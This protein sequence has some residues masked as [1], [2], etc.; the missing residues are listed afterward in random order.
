MK[1]GGMVGYYPGNIWLDFGIDRVKSQGQGHEKA[2]MW[3]RRRNALYRVPVLVVFVFV[4]K[5]WILHSNASL[6]FT[7]T[8]RFTLPGQ[9]RDFAPLLDA[10]AAQAVGAAQ[11]GE[12]LV[13]HAGRARDELQEAEPLLVVEALHGRPEPAHHDVALMVTWRREAE[14]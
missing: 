12:A 2:K 8:V 7:H 4:P 13:G 10:E 5:S 3:L 6:Y 9:R 11:R 14:S 1:F